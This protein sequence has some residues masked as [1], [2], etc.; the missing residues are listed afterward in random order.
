MPKYD[1]DNVPDDLIN[2]ST[3]M[4]ATPEVQNSLSTM[5]Q[6]SVNDYQIFVN[7][8]LM[9]ESKCKS[10]WDPGSCTKL[11]TF[12]DMKKPVNAPQTTLKFS[13]ASEVLFRHLLI[14]FEGPD[15]DK[16]YPST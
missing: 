4:V 10:F 9:S 13:M 12:S 3:G 14:I 11:L 15:V 7:Q 6:Q 16:K 8:R 2:I 1:L 5:I